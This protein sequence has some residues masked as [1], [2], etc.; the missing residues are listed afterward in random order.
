[1]TVTTILAGSFVLLGL[2]NVILGSMLQEHRTDLPRDAP[3]SGPSAWWQINVFVHARY[4]DRGRT[5]KRIMLVF[6]VVQA[7]LVITAVLSA[8]R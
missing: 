2:V 3:G 7:A 6:L 4:D 5:I 1:M 8:A